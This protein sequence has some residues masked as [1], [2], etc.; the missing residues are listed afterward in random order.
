MLIATLIFLEVVLLSWRSFYFVRFSL[1]SPVSYVL[2]V[3][4]LFSLDVIHEFT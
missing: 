3:A 4:V 2:L 1:L